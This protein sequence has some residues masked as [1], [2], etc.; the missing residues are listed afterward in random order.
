MI[1]SGFDWGSRGEI[2]LDWGGLVW[3]EIALQQLPA[4]C[5]V[6]AWASCSGLL[7]RYFLM[8]D[9]ITWIVQMTKLRPRDIK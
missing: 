2:W 8:T 7:T 6:C 9:I 3:W 1:K 5:L 4:Y